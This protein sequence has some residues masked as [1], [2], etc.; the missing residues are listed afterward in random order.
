MPIVAKSRSLNLLEPSG[1][2]IGLYMIA[3]PLHILNVGC[4]V[5]IVVTL[6]VLSCEGRLFKESNKTNQLFNGIYHFST[7][8]RTFREGT[9]DMT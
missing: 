8:D 3:L 1:P 4:F 7:R 2:V 9:G 5:L 6:A